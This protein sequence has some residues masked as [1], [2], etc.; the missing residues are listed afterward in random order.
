MKYN[1]L[2]PFEKNDRIRGVLTD[3]GWRTTGF[4]FNTFKYSKA[5]NFID[6]ECAPI[7]GRQDLSHRACGSISLAMVETY[8][9]F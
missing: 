7:G 5:N 4:H 9:A 3:P 2:N 8:D 1:T 6:W